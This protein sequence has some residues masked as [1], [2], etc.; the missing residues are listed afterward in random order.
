LDGG[1]GPPGGS[2]RLASEYES[3][4]DRRRSESNPDR[5][6]P[7]QRSF[8][9]RLSVR[10]RPTI[11]ELNTPYEAKLRQRYPNKLSGQSCRNDVPAC[12]VKVPEPGSEQAGL[13]DLG[14][15]DRWLRHPRLLYLGSS[16][17][18]FFQ[19]WVL[20][21]H[22]IVLDASA[23]TSLRRRGK[24]RVAHH[25]SGDAGFVPLETKRPYKGVWK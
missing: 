23:L 16:D 15:T 10:V 22:H 24:R 4:R 17:S 20:A 6:P 8:L 13:F 14:L 12:A 25:R 21:C 18:Q 9:A 5:H 2:W 19:L 7:I 11:A 1:C 3:T